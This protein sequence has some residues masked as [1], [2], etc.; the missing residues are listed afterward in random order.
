[1]KKLFSVTLI[2]ILALTL[3]ACGA[4]H[5]E[6]EPTEPTQEASALEMSMEKLL[7]EGWQA[8]DN[9]YVLNET[10]EYCDMEINVRPAINDIDLEIHYDYGENND[11]R[12]ESYAIDKTLGASVAAYWT[13][14]IVRE[15]DAEIENVNYMMY[16]GDKKVE[17]K[18]ITCEEALAIVQENDD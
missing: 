14:K 9:G 5:Q 18:T 8:T 10:T 2:I 7:D 6:N 13:A 15:T 17:E 12:A 16:V 4:K 11:K 3:S 1:M